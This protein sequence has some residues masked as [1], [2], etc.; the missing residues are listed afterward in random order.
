M[1][2]LIVKT[3]AANIFSNSNWGLHWLIAVVVARAVVA[4]VVADVAENGLFR[5]KIAVI[6]KQKIICIIGLWSLVA[7]LSRPTMISIVNIDH[8]LLLLLLLLLL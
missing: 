3:T 5:K 4:V 1:Q 2:L 8:C 6:F 7:T